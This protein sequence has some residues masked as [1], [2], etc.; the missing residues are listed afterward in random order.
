M[1]NLEAL[2][3]ETIES[4]KIKAEDEIKIEEVRSP[5]GKLMRTC[6]MK[7][8]Q[9]HGPMVIYDNNEQVAQK[10]NY[11]DNVLSGPAEFYQD[12]VPLMYTQF[13]NGTINGPA[14]LFNKGI[15]SAETTFK[16]GV[17]EGIFVSF[18]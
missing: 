1:D 14:T 7:D 18:D 8:C 2:A 15:K 16:N 11:E 13:Q 9:M 5:N 6:S 12:G 4:D 3:P 10:L 17:I